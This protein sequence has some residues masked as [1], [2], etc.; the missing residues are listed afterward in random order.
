MLLSVFAQIASSLHRARFKIMSWRGTYI[1]R[2]R[3]YRDEGLLV[4]Y[5]FPFVACLAYHAPTRPSASFGHCTPP[6]LFAGAQ[7]PDPPSTRARQPTH[8]QLYSS[9]QLFRASCS[10]CILDGMVVC[11]MPI[12]ALVCRRTFQASRG[13]HLEQLSAPSRARALLP[14]ASLAWAGRRSPRSL[15]I[16]GLRMPLA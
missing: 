11:R 6:G 9:P 1:C 15:G 5:E 12:A 4:L 14:L 8:P 16:I 10:I 3:I 2:W 13:S 7:A